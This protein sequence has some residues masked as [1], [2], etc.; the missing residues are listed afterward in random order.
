MTDE[1]QRLQTHT[2]R[3]CLSST[4]GQPLPNQG[5]HNS[6]QRAG[7]DAVTDSQH[8]SASRAVA[9]DCAAEPCFRARAAETGGHLGPRLSPVNTGVTEGRVKLKDV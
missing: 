8:L 7:Q 5:L 3:R 9:G 6:G 2:E 1:C 4:L